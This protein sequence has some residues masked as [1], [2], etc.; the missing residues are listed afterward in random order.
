MGFDDRSAMRDLAQTV[1]DHGHRNIAMISGLTLGNDRAL[2]RVQGVR[3][4][5]RKIGLDLEAMPLIQGTIIAKRGG[6][7]CRTDTASLG[8]NSGSLWP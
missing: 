4:A 6:G 1:I 7:L 2:D 8:Y 3:D 5:L